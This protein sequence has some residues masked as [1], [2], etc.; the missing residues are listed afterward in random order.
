MWRA[1][2]VFCRLLST[3]CSASIVAPGVRVGTTICSICL[4]L[5]WCQAM[6]R[7]KDQDAAH[8]HAQAYQ[9][10][11]NMTSRTRSWQVQGCM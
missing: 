5:T 2:I 6:S 9:Q 11:G 7:N 1:R 10:C 3:W 4:S 8:I